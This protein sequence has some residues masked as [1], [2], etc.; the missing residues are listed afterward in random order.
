MSE[1]TKERLV[2]YKDKKHQPAPDIPIKHHSHKKRPII[3]M[4][5]MNKSYFRFFSMGWR[6]FGKYT[7]LEIA[8]KVERDLHRKHPDLYKT[9]IVDKSI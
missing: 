8:E 1:T 4:Y 5:K 2:K 6:A 3:L 9:K 7:S